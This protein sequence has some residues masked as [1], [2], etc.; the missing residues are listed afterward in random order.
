MTPKRFRNLVYAWYK[1]EGRT[2]LPW[3]KTRDPY[4]ILVSEVMLQQ[5]QVERVIPFYEAFL[6]SFPDVR[7]LASA[8]L[9]RVLEKWQGLGYNRRAKML[10]EA[11]KVVVREHDGKIPKDVAALESLPGIG[12]YTARAVAAFSWNQ[13][14]VFVETN[15]RTAVI[16]HFFPNEKG[17]RDAEVLAILEKA[18]PQGEARSW[19]AALMDYGSYLKRSGVRINAKSASYAKQAPFRGSGREARGAVLRSLAKKPEKETYLMGILGP[20]R[21]EQV[22]E[23]LQ[24][25]LKE[26]LVEKARGT[27]RLPS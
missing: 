11:A 25:L 24:K 17:V 5:T 8:P 6:E 10:H 23:Q 19:Y 7:A 18:F 16:H 21:K 9:S 15:L 20:D 26:G 1:E 13:D 14:V 27:Y 2:H 12:H 3:R 4:R 22:R